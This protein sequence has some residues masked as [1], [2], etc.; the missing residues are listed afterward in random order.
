ML[1]RQDVDKYSHGLYTCFNAIPLTQG[2]WTRRPGTVRLQQAKFNDKLA[3]VFPFQ[4]SVTQTYILEFGNL[5]IRFFTSHGVLTK[6]AQ[7]VTA[8]TKASVAVLTYAGADTYANGDR[9]YLNDLAGM[10]QLN[11]REFVVTNVNTGANTFELYDS[12]GVAVNSTNYDAY[13]SGGT[14]NEI[15]EVVTTFTEAEL[16]EIRITQSADTLFIF[17][18]DHAPQKLVRN[19]ALSWTLS[20]LTFTDGPYDIINTGSTTLTPSAAT[21]SITLTASAVTDI[22]SG[23]GFLT[24]DVGRSIRMKEGSV[25][26]Y[27]KVT[28]YTSPTVVS[29]DVFLTLTNTSA[30]SSWR[31]GVWSTTTG[32]PTCGA[33]YDDRLVMAGADLY[34]QRLDASKTSNYTNFSPTATDGT[35]AADNAIAFTLNADDVNAIK[36]MVPNERALLAGT[37]RGEWQIKASA[38]NEAIT[39]TNISGKPST[40][41]GSANVAPVSAGKAVL[42]PQRAARKIREMAYVYTVDGFEAPDMTLL[43]EHVTRSGLIELAYQEQ[44]QAVM[45]GVRND[46]VFVGMT[47]E[48]TQDVVAWHRHELGGT[49]NAAGTAIPVVESMAVVPAPDATRDEAYSVVKRYINGGV[50]RTIEYASKIWEQEDEQEDAFYVDCGVTVL[51]SPASA[52]VKG[53]FPWEGQTLG[54]YVDGAKHI[55]VTVSNGKVTLERTGSV[56]TLGYFYNS[57][58]QTMPIDG[59]SQDGS[60]QGKTKRISRVGFW[61]IDT[62]GLKYGPDADNLTE[63]LVRRWGDT[64]GEPTGLFTGVARERFEADYGKLGQI[65][66][67]ADGPFPATVLAVMPQF[68][69]SD[70]S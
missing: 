52:T 57:D 7:N 70:D 64:Y 22:N 20:T 46:G 63:L 24:T 60:T 39:P 31:L 44:P 13:V 38:L 30:K 51:N 10:E 9:V 50:K 41:Y 26:G 37:S 35:V 58:G 18:P 2:G 4:Y 5:Y 12:D 42:F 16:A 14:V 47:Y 11:D 6:A 67:R 33:F 55:D 69:V 21:G 62:L 49:S 48:R 28:G 36:W 3:R 66:W 32:W 15:F 29:A 59:G 17:H 53:L 34:P 23:L 61:L 1:G 8:V 68:E 45:W 56:V 19:S 43:A 65:Y 25:W 27:V 54:C 40:R